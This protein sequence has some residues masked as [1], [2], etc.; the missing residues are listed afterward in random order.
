MTG[1]SGSSIT[2]G[3]EAVLYKPFDG[4]VLVSLVRRLLE[5]R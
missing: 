4:A 5:R 1:D 2:K 3:V